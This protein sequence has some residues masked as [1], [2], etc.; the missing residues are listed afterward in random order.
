MCHAGPQ[1]HAS[2]A[3]SPAPF[4]LPGTRIMARASTTARSG[5]PGVWRSTRRGRVTSKTLENAAIMGDSSLLPGP[6]ACNRASTLRRGAFPG[7]GRQPL[8][9]RHFGLR[10]GAPAATEPDRGVVGGHRKYNVRK[11]PLFSRYFSPPSPYL[12]CWA[13]PAA[14]IICYLKMTTTCTNPKPPRKV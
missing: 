5:C 10:D 7:W 12:S 2:R 8:L 13:L 14:D 1:A 11:R 3:L 6:V 4:L 9:H